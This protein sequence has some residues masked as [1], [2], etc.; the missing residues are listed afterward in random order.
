[1]RAATDDTA[2]GGEPTA[3]SA[4]T[5]LRVMD[6][7]AV[8]LSRKGYA[9]TRL[10][11]IAAEASVQSSAIYYYFD[12]RE[13]LL[14]AVMM[15]G[16]VEM[17]SH[18]TERLAALPPSADALDRIDT[19]VEAHL[20]LSLQ[21]SA[22]TTATIRNLGQVPEEIRGRLLAVEEE[23]G[24]L[25]QELFATAR[26]QRRIP[27]TIDLF[28]MRMLVLGAVNWAAEWWNPDAGSLDALVETAK[29]IVRRGIAAPRSV[30]LSPTFLAP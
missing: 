7:A 20:R 12:S 29:T 8:V 14:E 19:A 11:D 2:L 30:D 9:S 10:S 15:R 27:G 3:K 18:V 16:A 24:A 1:V 13:D 25:W 26:A 6:S 22:Y 23:Y 5:R 17:R 21:L 4:R 28:T